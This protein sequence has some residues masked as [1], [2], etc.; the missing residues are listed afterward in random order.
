MTAWETKE[1]PAKPK[2]WPLFRFA[3]RMRT[4][5]SPQVFMIKRAE[6]AGAL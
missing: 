4:R 3:F 5:R 2:L 6:A 1:A